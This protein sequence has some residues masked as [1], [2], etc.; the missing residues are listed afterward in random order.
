MLSLVFFFHVLQIPNEIKENV[1]TRNVV[2]VDTYN[3][4]QNFCL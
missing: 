2:L 1:T 4:S 3:Q